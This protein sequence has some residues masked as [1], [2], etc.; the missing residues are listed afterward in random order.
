[1]AQS[2]YS[3]QEQ[4]RHILSLSKMRNTSSYMSMKLK[5]CAANDSILSQFQMPQILEKAFILPEG[6]SLIQ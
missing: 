2:K 4:V 6:C 3:L 5:Y 1:M